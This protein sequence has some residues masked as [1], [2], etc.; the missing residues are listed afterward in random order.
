MS[1][2]DEDLL[3]LRSAND[4]CLE[5]R[6]RFDS[7]KVHE[8]CDAD[9]SI[10]LFSRNGHTYQGV[11]QW[12]KLLDY[13][14]ERVRFI[15]PCTAEAVEISAVGDIGWSTSS[16]EMELEWTG[17]NEQAVE[18]GPTRSRLTTIYARRPQGW[19]IVHMHISPESGMARPGGI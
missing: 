3:N 13:Y 7:A 17:A 19:Q 9:P 15:R 6:T 1:R 16:E 2:F 8:I 10:V 18:V 12:T 14:A 11:R 4:A 5:A